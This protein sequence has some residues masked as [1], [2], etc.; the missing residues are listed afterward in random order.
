MGEL[1]T[2]SRRAIQT[3]VNF[4]VFR[5]H[6]KSIDALCDEASMFASRL[7]PEN[8]ISI[9]HSQNGSQKSVIVWY[10]TSS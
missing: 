4:R 8:L 1:S 3:S 5:G 7:E 10:R 2:D 9:S 6:F